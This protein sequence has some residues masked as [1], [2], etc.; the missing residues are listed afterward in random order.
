MET[1][2]KKSFWAALAVAFLDNFGLSVVFILFAPLILNPQYGFFPASVS[3]GTKNILLGILVG[4][5]PL[6]TF[7][8]APFWGD[9]GDRWGRKKALLLSLLGTVFGHLITAVAIWM[10]SYVFLL[11]ARA[12][13]G[14]FSGNISICL[15]TVS[16]V[17]PDAKSKARNF[18][19]MMVCMGVGW[20]SAML[21]GGYLSDPTLVSFFNPSLPFYLV[22]A[23]TFIG[24]ILVKIWFAETHTQ[25]TTVHFDWM[26]SVHDIKTALMHREMR[27]IL[28][29][30]F[31]WTL[32]WYFTFQ[33]FTPISLERFHATQEQAASYLFVLGVCWVIGGVFINPLLVKRLSSRSLSLYSMLFTAVFIFLA[34]FTEN[35]FLFGLFFWISCLSAP[36]SISNILNI[37]SSSATPGMQGKAMGFSQSFQALAAV[38]VPFLGGE[39]ANISV[40][41]IFPLSA[42]LLFV[43]SSLVYLAKKG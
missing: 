11:V 24:Y 29:T 13:A 27:P 5:F 36:I 37:V 35:Y 19:I 31:M 22:S 9:A 6:L 26:K 1:T 33:W 43:A 30:T 2:H 32:G 42:I 17:S 4:V 3:E 7:F 20:I 38:L 23:L 40:G 14:L 25:H 8:S 21:L 12:V 41:L 16:D 10:E 18:G 15:A 28:Y 34:G 39:L